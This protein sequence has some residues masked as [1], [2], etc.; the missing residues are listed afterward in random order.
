M[1]EDTVKLPMIVSAAFVP[2]PAISGEPFVIQ[3]AVLELS[4]VPSIEA[5]VA[6]ELYAGEV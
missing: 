3:I 1:M 2:S 6:G 5:R 4:G